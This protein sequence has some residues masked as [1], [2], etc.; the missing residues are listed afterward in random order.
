[1][2]CSSDDTGAPVDPCSHVG[3]LAACLE[4]TKSQ[5]YYAATSSMY[6]DTMD[7]T[8]E[9]DGWPP[10][11]ERVARWE[12]PPWLLWASVQRPLTPSS[13]NQLS[14]GVASR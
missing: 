10:Y 13:T 5:E 12:R 8:V 3:A 7:Y 2:G 6:F 1:M 4:P 14:K 11:S 9:L